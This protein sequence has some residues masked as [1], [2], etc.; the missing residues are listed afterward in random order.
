MKI[1]IFIDVQNDFIEGSLKN[2]YAIA[3]MPNLVKLMQKIKEKNYYSMFTKD[4][5]Y[6]DYLNTLEGKYL[7]IKHCRKDTWGWEIHKDLKEDAKLVIPKITFGYPYWK[8]YIT[9]NDEVY[10]CGFC[11]DICV[12]S[13]ALAIRM[14]FPDNEIYVIEDCCAGV[15]P[16]KHDAAIEVMKSCQINVINLEE[17]E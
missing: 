5:H 14:L 9:E 7:P 10:L 6:Y 17:I 2:D 15:T 1:F 8:N 12:I 16:E 4:T 11:T 13:N 3:T